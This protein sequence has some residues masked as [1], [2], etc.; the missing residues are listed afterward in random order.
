MLILVLAAFSLIVIIDILGT[1]WIEQL[2]PCL[3]SQ[4]S[5]LLVTEATFVLYM[6]AV[7]KLQP[8]NTNRYYFPITPLLWIIVLGNVI[9]FKQVLFT[10]IKRTDVAEKAFLAVMMLFLAMASSGVVLSHIHHKVMFLFPRQE[11]VLEQIKQGERHSALFITTGKEYTVTA[12]C[13]E[14][15][16][17]S[18]AMCLDIGSEANLS[19]Y[20]IY[21]EDNSLL[22]LADEALDQQKL[23][24]Q[25]LKQTSYS[26]YTLIG[27]G[28][29][30]WWEDV[31][32]NYIYRFSK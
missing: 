31:E 19:E 26:T 10:H 4:I 3:K 15:A 20:D 9:I 25:I 29:G 22:V 12:H 16:Q 14:L 24:D 28:S 18:E 32:E 11:Q 23:V 2:N 13:L 6:L 27:R 1:L 7:A 17:C 5:M 21:D 30:V 8:F